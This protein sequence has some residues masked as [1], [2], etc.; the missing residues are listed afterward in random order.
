MFFVVLRVDDVYVQLCILKKII[1]TATKWRLMGAGRGWGLVT[2]PDPT[3]N[4]MLAKALFGITASHSIVPIIRRAMGMR[5][6]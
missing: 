6:D 3:S 1:D 4:A 5:P 2:Y